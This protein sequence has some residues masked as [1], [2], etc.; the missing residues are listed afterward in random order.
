MSKGPKRNINRR[1]F[2]KSA[3]SV[4]AVAAS[5][6]VVPS[7]NSALAQEDQQYNILIIGSFVALLFYVLQQ[8]ELAFI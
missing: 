7:F 4:A 3:G 1:D 5:V 8:S 2:V 6:A